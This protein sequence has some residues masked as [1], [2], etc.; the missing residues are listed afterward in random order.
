MKLSPQQMVKHTKRM[1]DNMK[2]ARN[3]RVAVGLPAE[4]VGGQVYGN[5][6]TVVAIGATHEFGATFMHPGGTGYIVE[7]GK[8]K[9][10][11]SS[12]GGA[13]AGFTKAHMITIPRRS[14]LRV[15]FQIKAD[16]MDE[17]V[18]NQ[19]RMVFEKGTDAKKA[20]GL[21][22]TIAVNI[23][24]GAFVSRGYGAWPDIKPSTKKAK[25]SSQLLVDNGILR[26][27]ITYVVRGA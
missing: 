7:N 16:E 3:A 6:M 4:K 26:G 9:F 14:F 1:A 21:I 20:L 10:V 12:R 2:I 5:G 13:V 17:A 18:A 11:S 25:G 19:F 24:K 22:G 8:A 27:S 23:V 15:P